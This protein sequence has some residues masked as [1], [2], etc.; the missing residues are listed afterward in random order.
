M[1]RKSVPSRQ[2]CSEHHECRGDQWCIDTT[3][4]VSVKPNTALRVTDVYCAAGNDD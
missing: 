3:L 1:Q 4:V 2:A